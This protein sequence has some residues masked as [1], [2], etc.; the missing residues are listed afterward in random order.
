MI[1]QQM[2]E[3]VPNLTSHFGRLQSRNAHRDHVHHLIHEVRQG[4]ITQL[5]PKEMEFSISFAGSPVANFIDIVARDMAEG[6]APLPALACVSGKMVTEADL[7]RAE[8]KNRI[9]DHYW[10][11]S[12]LEN[13]M[14]SAA[15]RYVSYGF[16]PIFIEPDVRH[17]RGHRPEAR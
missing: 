13:Q 8:M 16:L 6:I 15:D 7:K 9:G 3:R 11:H 5:F 10:L 2:P 14:L 4:N 17:P 12:N 1:V